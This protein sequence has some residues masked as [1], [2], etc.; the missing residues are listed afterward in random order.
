MKLARSGIGA[1]QPLVSHKKVDDG[2]VQ[3]LP[4][5]YLPGYVG[6]HHPDAQNTAIGLMQRLIHEV[7]MHRGLVNG[8]RGTA[9]RAAPWPRRARPW[10]AL[11]LAKSQS[12][13][14][15]SRAAIRTGACPRPV[16]DCA[17]TARTR[18][19]CDL[20]V[21]GIHLLEYQ[22]P[23]ANRRAGQGNGGSC[24]GRRPGS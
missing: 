6:N 23:A 3:L 9:P 21:N 12:P 13:G 10:P 19:G 16:P 18:P 7:H 5:A 1:G 2:G 22:R 15:P 11:R 24:R 14:L 17:P 20:L 8:R 4:G